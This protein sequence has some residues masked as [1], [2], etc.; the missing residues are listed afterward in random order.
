MQ[1]SVVRLQKSDGTVT[2][3]VEYKLKSNNYSE[4]TVVN[5]AD[6]WRERNVWYSPAFLFLDS[7]K[8]TLI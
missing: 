6:R 4:F 7:P 3:K 1:Y 2:R 8:E 5:V